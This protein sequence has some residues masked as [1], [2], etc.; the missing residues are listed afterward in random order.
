MME[1]F[2][3][4]AIAQ[5]TVR[6]RVSAKETKVKVTI[7]NQNSEIVDIPVNNQMRTKGT[8][9]IVLNTQKYAPGT[10]YV[11]L[12]N[13]NETVQSVKLVVVK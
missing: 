5:S 7:Y 4:P 8:Y 9:D 13:N 2:P 11:V 1:A 10:Y 12:D 6:I 3:N